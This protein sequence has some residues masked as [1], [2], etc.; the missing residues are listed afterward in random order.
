MKYRKTK[1]AKMIFAMTV[2]L[3]LFAFWLGSLQLNFQFLFHP[4]DSASV[5]LVGIGV[6]MFNFYDERPQKPSI[7]EI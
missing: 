6:F 7:E 2:P 1:N 5:V 4:L 3:T